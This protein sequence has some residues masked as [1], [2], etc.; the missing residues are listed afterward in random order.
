MIEN[1]FVQNVNSLIQ[2]ML[3]RRNVNIVKSLILGCNNI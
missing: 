1:V 2:R 3:I